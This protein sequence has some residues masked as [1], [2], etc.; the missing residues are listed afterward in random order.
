MPRR[1]NTHASPIGQAVPRGSQ[2]SS[3]SVAAAN[4]KTNPVSIPFTEKASAIMYAS[5][6]T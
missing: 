5:S 6:H 1:A 4:I 2:A 3:R